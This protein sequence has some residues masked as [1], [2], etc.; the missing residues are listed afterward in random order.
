V[1]VLGPTEAV[2][3]AYDFGKML[4][5]VKRGLAGSGVA[6]NERML[7]SC[8]IIASAVLGADKTA[9]RVARLTQPLWS[10]PLSACP[11]SVG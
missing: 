2:E 3:A 10:R 7:A 5:A 1:E 9:V 11:A 8:V 6:L 4:A